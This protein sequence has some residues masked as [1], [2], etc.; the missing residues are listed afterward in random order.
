MSHTIDKLLNSTGYSLPL[1]VDWSKIPKGYDWVAIS[2]KGDSGFVV[3]AFSSQPEHGRGRL[4]WEMKIPAGGRGSMKTIP[5]DVVS[6]CVSDWRLAIAHRHE[7]PH[8]NPDSAGIYPVT[9]STGD[10]TCGRWDGK[11]WSLWV[12]SFDPPEWDPVV[13]LNCK[14]VAWRMP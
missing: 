8:P 3:E 1:I 14:V 11:C 13:M 6:G 7:L 12:D 2:P 10:R 9:T 5:M 4:G